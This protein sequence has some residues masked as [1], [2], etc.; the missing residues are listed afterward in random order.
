[1]RG[2]DDQGRDAGSKPAQGGLAGQD[3]VRAPSEPKLRL[4]APTISLPK[5][6]GAIKGI[7]ETYTVNPAS[8]TASIAL[9]LPL[10]PAR[11]GALP[12]VRLRYDSGSG[13]SVVG[14]GWSLDLPT[15][16]RSTDKRLPRYRDQDVFLLQGAEEL[17]P[18][19]TW[20]GAAWSDD[21]FTS[22]AYAIARYRPRIEGDF[23]R[24]EKITHATLGT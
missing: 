15:I 3:G 10:T 19:S 24:I 23:A 9:P 2:T 6:G 16:R 18:A 8:G 13:N 7:D 17:V 5:G 4:D 11:G 22:G 14:L 21:A 1:M 12:P 20:N